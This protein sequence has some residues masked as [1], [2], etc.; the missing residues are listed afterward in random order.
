[1]SKINIPEWIEKTYRTYEITRYGGF[2]IELRDKMSG[3]VTNFF[4]LLDQ[5]TQLRVKQ[6]T[7]DDSFDEEDDF[8]FNKDKTNDKPKQPVYKV[9]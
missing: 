5:L 9:N 7:I 8:F 1:V 4:D 2:E 6:K 3:S